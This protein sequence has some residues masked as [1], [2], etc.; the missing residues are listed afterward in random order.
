MED[1]GFT[2]SGINRGE[3]WKDQF[4]PGSQNFFMMHPDRREKIFIVVKANKSPIDAR[5]KAA[6][7]RGIKMAEEFN[8][9]VSCFQCTCFSEV[10]CSS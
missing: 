4:L 7:K 3:N 10:S 2:V 9:A 1:F 5:G 6:L 8:C